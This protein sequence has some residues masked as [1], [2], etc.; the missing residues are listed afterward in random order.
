MRPVSPPV[1][2]V[3]NRFCP[4]EG[5]LGDQKDEEEADEE[6]WPDEERTQ[7]EKISETHEQFNQQV[8]EHVDTENHQ[9]DRKVPILK[10]PVQPTREQWERHQAT[11]T[12]FEFRRKRC[13]AGRAVRHKHPSKGRKTAIAPDIEGNRSTGKDLN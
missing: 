2:H 4:V 3:T 1:D 9:A 12:P 10:A 8:E 13:Q 5:E 7:L 11:H 6:T